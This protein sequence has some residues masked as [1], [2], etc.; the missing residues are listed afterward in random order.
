MTA[1]ER[2]QS[3]AE[4]CT[5]MGKWHWEQG[6]FERAV[7]YT[8]MGHNKANQAA[9]LKERRDPRRDLL[10][11]KYWSPGRLTQYMGFLSDAN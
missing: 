4:H 8:T 6:N 11:D 3:Y 7:F 1:Y 2:T 10:P 5:T 9:I